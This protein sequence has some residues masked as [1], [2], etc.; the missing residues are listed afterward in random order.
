MNG[1]ELKTFREY[2]GLTVDWLSSHMNVA[3]RTLKYWEASDG[4]I[5]ADVAQEI[6]A[7]LGAA[8]EMCNQVNGKLFQSAP[9]RTVTIRYQR[10]ADLWSAH[11][12]MNGL[13][14]SFHAR[15]LARIADRWVDDEN[16][17]VEIVW[18]DPEN[19]FEWLDGRK[20]S[21]RLRAAWATEQASE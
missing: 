10:E 15:C 3:P 18:F 20:D 16:V 12:E 7:L 4:P 6:H 19:Y 9:I 5:P 17:V 14:A 1:A 2:L 13:P 11:P 8:D 21:S